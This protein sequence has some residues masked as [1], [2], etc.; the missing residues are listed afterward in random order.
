VIISVSYIVVYS[1]VP[2]EVRDL[3]LN[4]GSH[5]IRVNWK[6]PIENSYCVTQFTINWVNILNGNNE[7]SIVTSEEDSFVIGNLDDCVEYEVSA[8]AV[9]EKNE[10]SSAVSGSTT[11]H[12]VGKYQIFL[13]VFEIGV[14]GRKI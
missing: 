5:N 6:K 7:S 8:R 12:T 9:N 1:A 3:S 11:T 2:N 4:P 10:S 13:S 14:S